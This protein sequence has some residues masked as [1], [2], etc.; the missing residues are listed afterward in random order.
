MSLA[1]GLSQRASSHAQGEFELTLVTQTPRGSFDDPSLPFPVVRQPNFNSLRKLIRSA[2]VVHVA[3]APF[4]P[5]CLDLC[6]ES[7]LSW[8]T[9]VFRPF[10]RPGSYSR[11]PKT[12]LARPFHGGTLHTLPGLRAFPKPFASFHLWLLTFFRRFLCQHVA[13]NITPTN[14]LAECFNCPE[15]RPF[16]RPANLATACAAPSQPPVPVLVFWAAL[17]PPRDFL[18]SSKQRACCSS[19]IAQSN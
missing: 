18:C 8:S 5:S 9:T 14:W 11:N 7:R 17:L 10:V 13:A 15:P 3:G 12:S 19:R 6:C 1:R 2:D 16:P 4:L